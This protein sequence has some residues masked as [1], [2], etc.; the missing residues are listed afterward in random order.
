MNFHLQNNRHNSGAKKK[1]FVAFVFLAVVLFG[2]DYVT[3]GSVANVARTPVQVVSSANTM[4]GSA[5][6]SVQ[7]AFARK[8]TLQRDQDRLKERI[9]ELELYAL[10]NLV[11]VAENEELRALLGE[12]DTVLHTGILA[13]VLSRGGMYPYGTLIISRG[14]DTQ[15]SVGSLVF[16]K[17]NIL[18]GKIEE[19]GKTN[20]TVRLLSAPAERTTVL[21]GSGER[22]TELTVQGIG[23]GNMVAEVARDADIRSG[24]PVVLASRETVIV[25]DVQDIETKSTDAF[26]RIRVRTPINL[27]TLR[28]VRVR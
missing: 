3:K 18:I 26:Q 21:V 20:A 5:I 11:L 28:F 24:D 2:V 25:G 4:I 6:V 27:H 10:N 22:L 17:G 13:N 8:T 7:Q 1:V 15:Y 9:A 16:G 23:N 12:E 14:A 19:I